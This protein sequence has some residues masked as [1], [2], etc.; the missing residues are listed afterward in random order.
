MP[1]RRGTG[2]RVQEKVIGLR[3]NVNDVATLEDFMR[4]HGLQNLSSALRVLLDIGLKTA[5]AGYAS[6]LDVHIANGR[7]EWLER[8][9]ASWRAAITEISKIG[10]E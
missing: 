4:A 6:T 9:N 8:V 7:S 5:V 2:V 3:L 1:R 10:L